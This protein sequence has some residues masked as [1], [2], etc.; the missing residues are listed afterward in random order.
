VLIVDSLVNDAWRSSSELTSL[1]LERLLRATHE[2]SPQTAL[3]VMEAAPPGLGEAV[4]FAKA[5]ILNHYHIPTCDFRYA[6]S[7]HSAL[8]KNGP[9]P[10][11]AAGDPNHPSWETHQRMADAVAVH[12]GGALHSACRRPARP[13]MA[14]LPTWPWWPN[15]TVWPRRELRSLDVCTQPRAVYSSSA[16]MAAESGGARRPELD[17]GWSLYED[18]PSKPGW[19]SEQPG[20]RIRFELAF[21]ARPR[22]SVAFLRSYES[23]GRVNVSLPGVGFWTV[24]D[25]LWDD[26]ASQTDV[27]WFGDDE[28]HVNENTNY[29]QMRP[30]STELLEVRLLHEAH[31]R[32]CK[33]KIM[34]VVSC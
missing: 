11:Q 9:V 10:G 18:R 3:L 33:F 30:Y 5:R 26:R 19:I 20:S 16:T 17:A 4:G 27:V 15:D 23:V 34:Q 29:V 21:G 28:A 8:W 25:A 22:F 12:W 14:E 1:A 6:A 24:V 2:L 31:Q 32:F 7:S 13:R